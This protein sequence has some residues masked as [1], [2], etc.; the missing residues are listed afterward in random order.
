MRQSKALLIDTPLSRRH[1]QGTMQKRLSVR[2]SGVVES[3]RSGGGSDSELSH[4]RT[5]QTNDLRR[6]ACTPISHSN[7]APTGSADQLEHC[8][9]SGRARDPVKPRIETTHVGRFAVGPDSEQ[10]QN[11]PRSLTK[12]L[13]RTRRSRTGNR[14]NRQRQTTSGFTTPNSHPAASRL[15]VVCVAASLNIPEKK[16]ISI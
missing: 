13:K 16:L 2:S 14:L 12:G 8:S 3:P 6:R 1:H 5:I 7:T 10:G 4:V 9:N 11:I 15:G